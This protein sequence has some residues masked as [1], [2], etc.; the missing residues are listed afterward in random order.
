MYML[1]DEQKARLVILRD[2]LN[3]NRKTVA[4]DMGTFCAL[5][6]EGGDYIEELTLSEFSQHGLIDKGTQCGASMCMLGWA[7]TIF[8]DLI[9]ID[10]QGYITDG[11]PDV[12]IKLFGIDNH[13]SGAGRFLFASDWAEEE[14]TNT[15]DHAIYRINRVL[16]ATTEYDYENLE[17]EFEDFYNGVG[18]YE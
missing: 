12:G 4:L 16:S 18:L 3:E 14:E 10:S 6:E 2:F 17:E 7:G 15:I 5:T 11:W 8:K 13:S 9:E 1:N